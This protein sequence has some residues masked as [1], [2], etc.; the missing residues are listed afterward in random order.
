MHLQAMQIPMLDP[1]LGGVQT[2][3]SQPA[4]SSHAGM[5]PEQRQVRGLG[6]TTR[7]H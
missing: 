6:S 7:L 3:V 5:T 1:S 4:R 2:L